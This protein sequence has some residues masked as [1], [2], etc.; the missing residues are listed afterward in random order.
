MSH[1]QL[2]IMTR[3]ALF[4]NAPSV[5]CRRRIRNVLVTVLYFTE[6]IAISRKRY[7][8]ETVAMDVIYRTAPSHDKRTYTHT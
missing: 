6:Q 7:K 4:C 5:Y 1:A 8:T 2:H 3:I